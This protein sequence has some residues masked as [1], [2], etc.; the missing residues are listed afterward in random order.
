[1][2]VYLVRHAIAVER[3]ALVSLDDASRELTDQGITRMRRAVRG[4]NKIGVEIDEIW[5][6]PLTR[7]RQTAEILAD[8]RG[9]H[10]RVRIAPALAPGGDV[11]TV[12]RELREA[13]RESSIALVG[14]EPDMGELATLLLT[15]KTG[16]FVPFKKGGIACVELDDGVPGTGELKW[17]LT[18]KQLRN[19]K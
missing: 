11:E 1:M 16:S 13:S 14:H 2:L 18:P 6:S 8:A 7:A 17:L 9:F 19:I 4:L 15:G 12:V 3:D 10:G 5:T